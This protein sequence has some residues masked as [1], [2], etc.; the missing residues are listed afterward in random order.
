VLIIVIDLNNIPFTIFGDQ[1]VTSVV[2]EVSDDG[3][4]GES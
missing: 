3:S 4:G 1:Q 2:V